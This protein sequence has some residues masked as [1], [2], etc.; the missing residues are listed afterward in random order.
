MLI[1]SI[2]LYDGKAVQWRRGREPVLEREDVFALLREFSLFGE[3]ALIDLNA[4]TGKGSNRELIER[5]LKLHPCRV[6]GGI[7]DL[8]TARHFL[9]A[10]ASRIIL[11]TAARE[12]FVRK[13]PRE[14]LIFAIDSKGDQWLSHGWRRESGHRTEDLLEE[15]AR[16]CCEFLYT[17]VEK[18]GMMRGL[19]RERVRRIA[20]RSPVPLTVAGGITSLDDIRFLR[21]LG[22]NGQI[23]MAL[24]T[25]KLD[26]KDCL[27]ARIDF[28]KAP[29]VPTVVQD[30]DN[31][32]VLMLAY[33]S[34]E[35]L[36]R[37]LE[38]RRGVYYSRSRNRL[39]RKGDGSGHV[40]RLIKVDVD[41]DGDSLLFQVEQSGPACHFNR[42]SC[43]P[44]V[45][46]RFDLARLDRVL[47]S[48]RERLPEGSYSARLFTEPQLRAEKL[49][50]ETEELIE[51]G[52]FEETRWEAADLLYFTLVQARSRGVSLA[53]ITAELRSRHGNT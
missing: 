21:G 36:A 18:E 40:Q 50:E 14:A 24:Y 3:V 32:D 20:E 6:G 29:L 35:S 12:P 45:A 25:G 1:P 2:D 42:R 47:A 23:G 49:R 52:N 8:E 41:C 31:G 38:E 7:R 27:M 16:G 17:Q 34:R 11:G 37:A 44:G 46:P 43:F 13:L 39:W 15:L 22:A 28:D 53:D 30:A 48:R 4:A 9:K 26:L 33:S 10:G 19:D 5:L 51:A